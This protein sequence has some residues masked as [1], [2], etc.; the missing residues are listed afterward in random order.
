LS[1]I[2]QL[3]FQRFQIHCIHVWANLEYF[4]HYEW[5]S[6]CPYHRMKTFFKFGYV[7]QSKQIDIVTIN[8][9]VI[10]ILHVKDRR[11]ES[12]WKDSQG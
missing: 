8:T 3:G 1:N 7:K 5:D 6:Q 9:Y 2:H 11:L 4:K 10:Y 12:S